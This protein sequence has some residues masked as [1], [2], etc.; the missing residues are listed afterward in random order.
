MGNRSGQVNMAHSFPPDNGTG[1]FHA[2]FVADY[3]F[4]ADAFVF[5]AIAFPVLGR[6]ENPFAK[7]SVFFRL[8]GPVIDCFRLQN[9]AVRPFV[10]LLRRG[11]LKPNAVK[12]QNRHVKVG[13]KSCSG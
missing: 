12:F 7:E 5:A 6:P 11:N 8:L 1:D 2:A 13:H 3:A 9:F 4:V 10:D